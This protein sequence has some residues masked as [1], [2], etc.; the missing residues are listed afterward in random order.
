MESLW[1]Q[2][3]GVPHSQLGAAAWSSAWVR[4]ENTLLLPLLWCECWVGREKLGLGDFQVA[5]T[6]VALWRCYTQSRVGTG[7]RKVA[8]RGSQAS[9]PR[10]LFT[11]LLPAPLAGSGACDFCTAASWS[12]VSD[13]YSQNVTLQ[14][15]LTDFLSQYSKH[16]SGFIPRGEETNSNAAFLGD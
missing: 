15:R 4:M 1:S 12:S 13:Q 10:G 8:V 5:V 2:P 16:V 14:G 9:L 7:G 11:G 6:L 3:G